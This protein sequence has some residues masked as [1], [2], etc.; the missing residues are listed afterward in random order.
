MLEPNWNQE[1]PSLADALGIWKQPVFTSAP[2]ENASVEKLLTELCAT[3]VNGGAVFGRF[4]FANIPNLHWF[5]SRNRFD[6]IHFIEHL[7]CSDAFRV[8][9]PQIKSPKTLEPIKWEW[10]SSYLIAGD[11]ARTL[12]TGGAYEKFKRGGREALTI[13]ERA[14]FA[15]FEDRFEDVQIF[16][17]WVPWSDWYY[18]VA[19]DMT[20]VGI[21]KR[22]LTAWV[23]CLT[24]TD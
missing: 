2:I 24:D 3:H 1:R 9:L 19:W 21:D 17:A 12:M 8:T 7:L 10:W 14:R 4:K 11:W 18:D 20:W 13:G 6:E 23:L 15:L 5:V 22:D 16:R